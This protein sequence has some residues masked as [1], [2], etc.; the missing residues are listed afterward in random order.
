VRDESDLDARLEVLAPI[1]D[2]DLQPP[3]SIAARRTTIRF[4]IQSFVTGSGCS[5]GA[6]MI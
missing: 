6:S 2:V 4:D 3:A 1:L 5:I